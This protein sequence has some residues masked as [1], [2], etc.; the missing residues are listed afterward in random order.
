MASTRTSPWSCCICTRAGSCPGCKGEVGEVLGGGGVAEDVLLVPLDEGLWRGDEVDAVHEEVVLAEV[1]R[2]DGVRHLVRHHPGHRDVGHEVAG[3][4]GAKEGAEVKNGRYF[5]I[6]I[7]QSCV[8]YLHF[9]TN[10]VVRNT[11]KK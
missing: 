4:G 1:R 3:G 7:L 5:T 2:V 8:N 11:R 10:K 6:K 9:L